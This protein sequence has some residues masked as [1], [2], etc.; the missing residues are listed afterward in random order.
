[1]SSPDFVTVPEPGQGRDGWTAEGSPALS[2]SRG[3]LGALPRNSTS[4]GDK[5]EEK[6]KES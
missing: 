3:M 1:M 6:E 4:F 5:E 2:K